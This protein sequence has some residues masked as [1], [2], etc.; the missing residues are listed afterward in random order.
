MGGEGEG[1]GGHQ[2]AFDYCWERSLDPNSTPSR[3]IP[4]HQKTK[5][6][7]KCSRSPKSPKTPGS[8]FSKSPKT[9]G[10][11]YACSK[12]PVSD[13]VGL[14][15]EELRK[16]KL[17]LLSSSPDKNIEVVLPRKPSQIKFSAVISLQLAPVEMFWMKPK[18]R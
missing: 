7:A 6:S 17:T 16:L 1:V 11:D 4:G 18:L 3:P 8:D 10:S 14:P 9:P 2:Y 15:D 12:S 13:I 5:P